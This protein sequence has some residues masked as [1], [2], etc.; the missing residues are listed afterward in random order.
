MEKKLYDCVPVHGPQGLKGGCKAYAC[1]NCM[2]FFAE[3]SVA[4]HWQRDCL[5]S[6][7]PYSC[8]IEHNK[9]YPHNYVQLK[10]HDIKACRMLA[11]MWGV[12]MN[13]IP[14]GCPQIQNDSRT[15]SIPAD[16]IGQS[17][18]RPTPA[19]FDQLGPMLEKLKAYTDKISTP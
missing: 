17:P 1:Y 12:D 4:F 2:E 15:D 5:D 11:K 6:C 8:E 3:L 9:W 19:E 16:P 13:S 18:T 14:D 7:A 10:K